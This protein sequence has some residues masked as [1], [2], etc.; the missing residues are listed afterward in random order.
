LKDTALTYLRA[1]LCVLPAI[2]QEKRPT[3]TSWKQYQ[4]RLPTEWQVRTWFAEEMP[5]CVLT[6]AISGNLEMI[7]FDNGGDRC[8]PSRFLPVFP[9][10]CRGDGERLDAAPRIARPQRALIW[11]PGSREGAVGRG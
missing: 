7:D 10:R 9:G 1:G 6:G 8:E 11:M 2:L 5:A 3:L 4:R